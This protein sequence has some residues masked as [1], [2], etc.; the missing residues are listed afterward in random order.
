MAERHED[1]ADQDR[2]A[3]AER[4]I[5]EIAAEEGGEINEPGVG[6]VNIERAGLVELEMIREIK[7]QKRSHTIIA[8]SL[9]NFGAEEDEKAFGVAEEFVS[10]VSERFAIEGCHLAAF[11]VKAARG[12][13]EWSRP[14][15][16]MI[17]S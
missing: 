15:G 4:S 8:K 11:S 9:P 7:N 6:R 16:S 2:L 13:G 17:E 14:R 10:A 5:G 12:R 3:L 1:S